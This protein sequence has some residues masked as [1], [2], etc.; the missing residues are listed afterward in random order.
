MIMKKEFLKLTLIYLLLSTCGFA[1]SQETVDLKYNFVKGKTYV[2]NTQVTQNMVQT[3]G[4]QE[5]KILVEL[6]SENEYAI[7]GV[8]ADGNATVLISFKGMSVHQNMP[9]RDT[10][11][12][13][14]DMKDKNR[15]VF[16]KE[17][18]SLSS[19]KVDSSDVT[20]TISQ[21]DLG[22][23]KTL[24]GKSVKVGD[25]WQDKIVE[26]KKSAKGNPFAM[27]MNT[28]MEYTLV[29]K[30]TQNGKECFKISYSGNM[31]VAGKGTQMGMEMF[32]EGTGKTGGF[33]YFDNK[34][35]M[36]IYAEDDTEMNMN[37]AVSGPQN[38][39]IPMTQTVKTVT[40]FEEK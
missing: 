24:P 1:F 14:K 13:Y 17:G 37:I 18:K 9:G 10:T 29:G 36:V 4:A 25:K 15:V 39:T 6:K 22:K 16:S 20:G 35:S 8:E 12:N 5:M 32:I 23:L 27:D 19:V 34:K 26:N 3:M 33:L 28:D 38:M 30:E 31:T 21:M 11:L 2:Q 7:E 40:T